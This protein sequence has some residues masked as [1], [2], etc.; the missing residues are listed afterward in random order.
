MRE[1]IDRFRA[2]TMQDESRPAARAWFFRRGVW[3][4]V[5]VLMLVS[6]GLLQGSGSAIRWPTGSLSSRP[7]SR[8]S[9]PP[10]DPAI[11]RRFGGSLRNA[12]QASNKEKE[13]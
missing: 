10:G 13:P 2:E 11:P 4:A 12:E 3:A 9:S 5:S 1:R 8:A 6:G 7:G